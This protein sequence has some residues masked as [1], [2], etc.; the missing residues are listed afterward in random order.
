M[1]IYIDDSTKLSS[2][3]EEFSRTYP[4]LM[5]RFF[6][7]DSDFKH[8]YSK[9]IQVLD[10]ITVG[11]CR[12]Q[13]ESGELSLFPEM[14]VADLENILA[15]HFGLSAQIL[16]KSGSVW[17]NASN[18]DFWSLEEQNKQGEK[19]SAYLDKHEENKKNK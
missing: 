18:T 14:S 1:K 6:K 3:A 11:K 5:L 13:K 17:L 12:G 10:G 4:F 19:V 2:I 7:D 8:P 16:R 9:Q 15:D